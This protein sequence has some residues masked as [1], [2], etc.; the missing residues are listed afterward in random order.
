MFQTKYTQNSVI[1]ADFTEYDRVRK[2]T[3]YFHITLNRLNSIRQLLCLF[4]LLLAHSKEVAPL[5]Y[6]PEG[7]KAFLVIN[8]Y[9][10]I[11]TREIHNCLKSDTCI[12]E[13][14]LII[15]L[16]VIDLQKSL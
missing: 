11:W 12:Q 2:I 5:A 6:L 16:G 7:I 3:R 1:L 10:C 14:A 13:G 8:K 15:W 4:F 9:Q